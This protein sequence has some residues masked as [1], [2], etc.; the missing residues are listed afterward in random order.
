MKNTCAVIF[1]VIAPLAIWSQERVRISPAT[2]PGIMVP[3]AVSFLGA[4]LVAAHLAAPSS[5]SWQTN[6]I[7]EL[8][9]QGY[10]NA[11]IMR[12][13][14]IGFGGLLG[15]AMLME[16]LDDPGTWASTLPTM[17][18]ALSISMTGIWS[19]SPFETDTPY[20]TDEAEMHSLFAN[21]AGFAFSGAILGFLIKEDDW[22]MKLVHAAGLSVVAFSSIMFNVQPEYKGVYQRLLWIGGLSWLT[23]SFV[24]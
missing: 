17:A 22:K 23:A 4:S 9:G 1:L 16:F 19:T 10:G 6:T 13:G 18:Y 21:I 20:S 5:Y 8:G 11:W 2:E 7:S 14:F 12:T 3:V 15:S 24:L